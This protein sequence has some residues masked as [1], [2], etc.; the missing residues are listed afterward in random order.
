MN[1]N[2]TSAI[3]KQMDRAMERESGLKRGMKGRHIFMISLGGVIGTGLFLSS[4]FTLNAAGPGGAVLAY[5]VGGLSMYMV[6]LCL[7][8]LAVAIP[9]AGSFQ[10]YSR[11]FIH[12]SAGFTVGWMY[13]LNGVITIAADLVVAGM[14]LNTLF[15]ST[16]VTFWIVFWLIVLTALNC[17]SVN[18]FGEAEFW[19][20]SI[21]VLAI[22]VLLI[23]GVMYMAGM[24]GPKEA[25][26]FTHYFDNG[27][28]FPNG[29][30]PV[31][32]AMVAVAYSFNGTEIIGITAGESDH[33]E[34]SIPT[35]VNN[36]AIRTLL[37][38][39]ASIIVIAAIVPWQEAGVE[40][41]IFAVVFQK[42]GIP[43]AFEIMTLVVVTSALSCG[44]S[45]VY[46][47][48]RMLWSMARDGA[49]PA[50][51]G[52]L[53]KNQVPLIAML[54]T[55]ACSIPALLAEIVASAST[56]YI[57]LISVAGLAGVWGWMAICLAQFNFRRRIVAAGK[58]DTLKYKTPFYPIVPIIGFGINL[59][60]LVGSGFDPDT[61][62][63]LYAFVPFLIALFICY[64]LFVAKKHKE[65]D[66]ALLG[67]DK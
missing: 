30:S 57:I 61:R 39:V 26:G 47:T 25:I 16:S 27:G 50:I 55:M 67:G 1:S 40:E 9:V 31:F 12:P 7:G 22:I 41:S 53:S 11:E 60:V 5:L 21:K 56:V 42:S 64:Q 54:I 4:G 34:K 6:M 63:G 24:I 17:L 48:T 49:A 15:P 52:K 46:C 23:V 2:E 33:P 62:I 65:D 37:C 45:W 18:I 8:E 43:Y 19:F 28:M 13:W 14:L 20:C 38:Y 35:A 10:T 3:D 29:V 32:A 36:T 59:V 58:L 51:A 44:N 66:A